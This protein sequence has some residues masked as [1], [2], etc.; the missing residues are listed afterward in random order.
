MKVVGGKRVIEK[1]PG[2]GILKGNYVRKSIGQAHSLRNHLIISELG[3]EAGYWKGVASLLSLI[4]L[5][6]ETRTE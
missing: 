4:C 1:D 6:W 3:M 2:L 5:H